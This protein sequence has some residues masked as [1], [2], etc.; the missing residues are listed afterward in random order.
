MFGLRFP[1]SNVSQNL[2][3][4]FTTEYAEASEHENHR[5]LL[6]ALCGLRGA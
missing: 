1:V 3:W 4:R 6:R 5:R 2:A